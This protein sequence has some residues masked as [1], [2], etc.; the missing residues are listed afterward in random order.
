MSKDPAFLFYPGDWLG[1]TL[2]M[3]FEEKGAYLELLMLQ[4]NRG[5]MECHMIGQTVGQI[6]DKIKSKF[7][8]DE[9]GLWFNERLE[10][11]KNKRSLYVSSRRNN[12]K[13]K[14]K[15]SK[16]AGHM[17]GQMTSHME[18]EDENEIIV[19]S[20]RVKVKFIKP[21]KE[22][23]LQYFS[24]KGYKLDVG[25][26]AFEYYDVADWKDSQGRQVRNWK[27]KMNAV[28]FKPENKKQSETILA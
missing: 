9:N 28:W 17:N 26:R 12:M 19:K 8:Q 2:G 1:G 6:W 14:N 20:K 10:I 4:F 22:E 3:T 23:V 15:Y 5:H 7:V 13:G 25:K 24:E 18:N 21:T 27:Q 16:E 11:E